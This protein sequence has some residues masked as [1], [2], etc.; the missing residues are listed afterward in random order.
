[1]ND[2]DD[3]EHHQLR[4]SLGAFVLGQL[5]D[6]EARRV[7]E[8]LASC[9]GCRAE[10]DELL[11]VASALADVRRAGG[12]PA[13]VDAA[14]ADLGDR[15][16]ESVDAARRRDARNRWLRTASLA[17][18]AA[19]VAAIVLVAG[20]RLTEPDEAPPGP[21]EAVPVSVLDPA[22]TASADV[23]PHTWGVE[24]KLR[25][26]G[27]ERGDRY[28]VVVLGLDGRRYSAGE[29]VGTGGKEMLCNLNSSVVRDRADGFEVRDADG[30]V[31]VRSDFA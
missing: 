11:P 5:S 2:H 15:V 21:L 30:T 22:V 9:A 1:M 29:F 26:R 13:P 20:L 24:V 28:R 27:F 18:A 17:G 23:V 25:A 14:P 6:E 16:V 4:T 19:A 31:V 8:H 3:S 12:G 10:S 7:E